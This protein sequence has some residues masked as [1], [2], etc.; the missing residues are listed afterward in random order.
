MG[1]QGPEGSRLLAL[2]PEVKT[3]SVDAQEGRVV[4]PGSKRQDLKSSSHS[5]LSACP[6]LSGWHLPTLRAELPCSVSESNARLLGTQT[7]P[8]KRA[9]FTRSP[10]N[11]HSSQVDTIS[12]MK[13]L[14]TEKKLKK[15]QINGNKSCALM[16][17]KR[18]PIKANHKLSAIS[19]KTPVTLTT[20]REK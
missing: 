6:W 2:S 12:E 17:L 5:V 20:E 9:F 1:D 7:Y 8:H 10:G 13:D 19:I 11:P 16:L 3:W 4:N 15:T 18:P 14:Y